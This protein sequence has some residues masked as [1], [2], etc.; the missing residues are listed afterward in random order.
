MLMLMFIPEI[1]DVEGVDV[2]SSTHP[3]SHGD[4]LFTEQVYGEAPSLRAAH[5]S[6]RASRVIQ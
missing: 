3:T 4:S 1:H 6:D 2:R 5:C